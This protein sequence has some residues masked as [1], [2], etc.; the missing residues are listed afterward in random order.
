MGVSSERRLRLVAACAALILVGAALTLAGHLAA[1]SDHTAQ[2]VGVAPAVVPPPTAAPSTTTSTI[3]PPQVPV[4]TELAT[5]HG[6]I[7]TYAQPDGPENGTVGIWY[8]YALTLPVIADQGDWLQ[9]RLPQRPNQSTAWVR[10]AD[11]TAGA[12]PYRIVVGLTA[13]RLEVFKSGYA[14]MNFPV[15]VG[16]PRTP[17]VVGNYFITVHAPAPN[18]AY[19]PFV[20]STSAHSD[21]IQ[22]WE[23]AGD[24]II[25]IHGPID[26]YADSLIGTGRARVSNGCI[27][28]HD[29]DL[30][31]LSVIPIG[32]PLDIQA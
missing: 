17:T 16:T 15:G 32:T 13:Q 2:A 24:A 22:S 19:G 1:P 8:G 4:S 27:R 29:A 30:A 11:V 21:A 18:A 3:P 6:A 14:V 23:G 9:V 12:T 20:L 5:T 26:S 31:Q 28:L 10:R 7:A 25:A